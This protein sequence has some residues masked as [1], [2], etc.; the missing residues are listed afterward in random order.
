MSAFIS[1]ISLFVTIAMSIGIIYLGIKTNMLKDIST[2]KKM[3]YSFSRVQMAWWTVVVIG[4]YIYIIMNRTGWAD[5]ATFTNNIISR[6]ALILMG[7]GASTTVAGRII[8]NSQSDSDRHQDEDSEGFIL[9]IL[10][11]ANGVSIHRFQSL[12][13]NFIFGI[14]FMVKVYSYVHSSAAAVSM[15]EFS[16]TELALLGLSSAA[17]VTLKVGENSSSVQ[18]QG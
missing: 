7:I 11:D 17:Y 4:S 10:S 13:F 1:I 18:T 8:D 6:S 3:P 12:I 2:A 16:N 15:P 5:T 9:D 14:M